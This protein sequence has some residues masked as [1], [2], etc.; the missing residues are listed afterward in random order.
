MPLIEEK[1][2]FPYCFLMYEKNNNRYM[3]VYSSVNV[4]FR[5]RNEIV[6]PHGKY[7]LYWYNFDYSSWQDF[8]SGAYLSDTLLNHFAEENESHRYYKQFLYSNIDIKYNGEVVFYSTNYSQYL[9]ILNW[10]SAGFYQTFKRNTKFILTI[11]IGLFISLFALVL[12]N[13]S[14]NKF[15][16]KRTVSKRFEKVKWRKKL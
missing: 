5:N 3:L 1:E 12:L 8:D 6:I 13:Y 15:M 16:G 14:F 9:N 10:F 4:T 11:G 7:L 2:G